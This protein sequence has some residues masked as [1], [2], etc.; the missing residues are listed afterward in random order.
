[1]TMDFAWRFT[2]GITPQ[3]GRL[4]VPNDALT[5]GA[6][7]GIFQGLLAV[8]VLLPWLPLIQRM[9]HQYVLT[10]F[11]FAVGVVAFIVGA[12]LAPYTD[13]R[14]R[15]VDV[16]VFRQTELGVSNTTISLS[17][18]NPGAMTDVCQKNQF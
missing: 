7:W 5:L 12:F 4:G 2:L 6:F 3:L 1:M 8:L 14:P 10:T 9:R 11:F 18:P 16:V 17:A 13:V 15:R